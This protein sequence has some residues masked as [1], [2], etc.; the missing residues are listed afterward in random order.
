MISE[1]ITPQT[2]ED[3]WLRLMRITAGSGS[4]A[5]VK[6]NFWGV[7]DLYTTQK[8]MEQS[9]SQYKVLVQDVKRTR[10]DEKFFCNNNIRRVMKNA[11]LC[12]CA[13]YRLEYMQVS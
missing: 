7:L 5:L 3:D 10:S 6:A 2:R 9:V 8:E 1:F 12:F 13:Y 11:L 4:L